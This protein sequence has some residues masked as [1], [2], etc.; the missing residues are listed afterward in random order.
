MSGRHGAHHRPCRHQTKHD[1]H[2]PESPVTALPKCNLLCISRV[3]RSKSTQKHA[4]ARVSPNARPRRAPSSS[5]R[6]ES[7]S[8][9]KSASTL[10]KVIYMVMNTYICG[11]FEKESQQRGAS[12]SSGRNHTDYIYIYTYIHPV[13][14]P[15]PKIRRRIEWDGLFE[16][17]L[18]P[19]LLYYPL[20]CKNER[21]CPTGSRN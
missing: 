3:N 1:D 8:T 2:L 12:L 21:F 10:M 4:K 16:L 18:E 15:R 19:R 5:P 7:E 6:S 11:T 9:S 14:H 20:Y 13:V 17:S